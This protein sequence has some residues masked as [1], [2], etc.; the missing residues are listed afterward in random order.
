MNRTYLGDAVYAELEVQWGLK[1][2]IPKS[3]MTQ[4]QIKFAAGLA[5]IQAKH[6]C[7][8]EGREVPEGDSDLRDHFYRHTCLILERWGIPTPE[9]WPGIGKERAQRSAA[10]KD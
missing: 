8:Y 6:E 9:V 10:G 1:Y 7:G 3:K 4:A 5:G 2:I